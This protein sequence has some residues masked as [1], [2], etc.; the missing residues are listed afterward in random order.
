M[1]NATSLLKALED[2]GSHLHNGLVVYVPFLQ[3]VFC[4]V[5]LALADWLLMLPFMLMASIAAELTKLH[6][7]YRTARV[8]PRATV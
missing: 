8:E 3:G 1:P 4:T 5:P 2:L 6:V 7:R